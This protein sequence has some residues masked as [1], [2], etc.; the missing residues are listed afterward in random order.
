M[1]LQMTRMGRL[2]GLSVGDWV[3]LICGLVLAGLL[4]VL[5]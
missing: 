5:T 2:F 1:F 3:V 4:L